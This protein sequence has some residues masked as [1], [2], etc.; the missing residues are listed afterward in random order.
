MSILVNRATRIVV[1]GLGDEAGRRHA[2]ACREYG[3]GKRCVVA[4]VVAG[5]SVHRFD[6]IPV[7][8]SVAE[9]RAATGANACM[10]HDDAER[11]GAAIDEAAEAGMP[12]IVCVGNGVPAAS[13]AR[14][15]DA[16]RRGGT[17][18]LGPGCAGVMTPDEVRIGN[19]PGEAPQRGRI[20]VILR[21]PALLAEV[22]RQF[23]QHGLGASTVVSLSD[24]CRAG[25]SHL[26]LLQLFE[27]DAG[28]DAVLLAGPIDDESEAACAAWI[29]T[30]LRKPLIGW[31]ADS[32]PAASQRARLAA[33]GAH[34][35]HELASLGTLTASVVEPQWLPFD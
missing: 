13:L 30:H 16:L 26:E 11:A 27:A 14:A 7:F 25:L 28:T 21:S 20:G 23:R 33:C 5:G 19:L 3:Q 4:G 24:P 34:M 2:T 31:I 35:T 12:L 8:E 32:G 9:A 15:A 22:A 17:R 10:V 1:H 29:A 18:L 6:G